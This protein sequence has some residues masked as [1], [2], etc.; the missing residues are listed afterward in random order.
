MKHRVALAPLFFAILVLLAAC[1]TSVR[2]ADP[3]KTDPQKTEPIVLTVEG[4][5]FMPA[6]RL[7]AAARVTLDYGDETVTAITLPA[8]DH[9]IPSHQ[10]ATTAAS[11]IVEMTIEPPSA[12]DTLNLGFTG[13][14][15]GNAEFELG[16]SELAWT[17]YHPVNPENPLLPFVSPGW[18]V[19]DDVLAV[20][21]TVTELSGLQDY[22]R[23]RIICV[24][25]QHIVE[26]DMSGLSRLES[27]EAFFSRVSRTNFAG[28]T[29]LRRCCLENTG[30][31]ESWRMVNGERIT[32]SVLD[33]ADCPNLQDLRGTGDDH[34]GVRFHPAVLEGPDDRGGLWHFCKMGNGR[35]HDIEIVGEPA[36]PMQPALFTSLLQY[37]FSGSPVVGETLNLSGS[38]VG[39][40]WAEGIGVSS[41]NA[42]NCTNL[43]DLNGSYNLLA[44]VNITG[45]SSLYGLTLHNCGLTSAQVD[46]IL[47][48]LVSLNNQG[49][50]KYVNLANEGTEHANAAPSAAGLAS[51]A[52]LEAADWDV[53]VPE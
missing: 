5:V 42:T 53:T 45:C 23:L 35:M 49:S 20:V 46:A 14:D 34:T 47:A 26:L 10:F 7:S 52:L 36:G 4:S 16:I 30:A 39:S 12:L 15:G 37:W 50:W 9:V 51:I 33:L 18:G 24:E 40:V 44:S 32:E 8:G 19:D 2:T 21:G 11:H 3:E 38:Q 17:N 28:C 48:S 6:I 22:D 29:A 1:T 27:L 43:G 25:Y 31:N 41:I 13:G